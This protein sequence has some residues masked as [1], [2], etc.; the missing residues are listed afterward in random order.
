MVLA[1]EFILRYLY[2]KPIGSRPNVKTA[3]PLDSKVKQML[4]AL[5]FSSLCIYVRCA[6]PCFHPLSEL[7]RAL[8]GRGTVRSSLRT[9]GRATSSTRNA[10]SVRHPRS[11]ARRSPGLNVT[12]MQSSWTLS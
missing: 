1:A 3:Y 6:R 8:L 9:A 12:C 2:D 11:W 4:G 7:T 10:T 5:T